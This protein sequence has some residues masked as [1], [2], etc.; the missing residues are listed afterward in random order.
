MRIE[1]WVTRIRRASFALA[2]EV[3][4]DDILYAR[5]ASLLVPYDRTESRPRRLSPEER[6]ALAEYLEPSKQP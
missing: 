5:A 1:T 4:D 3:R 6:A 2:Y